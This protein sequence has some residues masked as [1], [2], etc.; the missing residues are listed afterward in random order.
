MSSIEKYGTNNMKVLVTGSNGFI[1]KHMCLKLQRLGHEVLPFDIDKNEADLKE[2]VA[3][4][5][6]IKSNENFKE[7]CRTQV[8]IELPPRSIMEFMSTNVGNHMIISYA[9]EANTFMALMDLYNVDDK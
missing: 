2:Y 4:E 8:M 9:K 7:Y 3:I 5:G 1:G 6:T